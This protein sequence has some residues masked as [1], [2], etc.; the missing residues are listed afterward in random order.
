MTPDGKRSER[1]SDEGHANPRETGG[2]AEVK[3]HREI[4]HQ[5]RDADR[6]ALQL[7]AIGRVPIPR[8]DQVAFYGALAAL[9]AAGLVEWPAAVVIGAGHALVSN[10]P[11]QAEAKP[12]IAD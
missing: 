6:F 7:P 8:P 9:V 4:A 11:E 5:V 1:P 3:S 2:D 12:A 10:R